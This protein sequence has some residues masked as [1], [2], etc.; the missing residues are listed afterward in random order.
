MELDLE[1]LG[2]EGIHAI[3]YHQH[4]TID[5]IEHRQVEN[6]SQKIRML[7]K[8]SGPDLE[9]LGPLSLV[10]FEIVGAL[11]KELKLVIGVVRE[12]ENTCQV[13]VKLVKVPKVRIIVSVDLLGDIIHD[14]KWV[15]TKQIFNLHKVDKVQQKGIFKGQLCLFQNVIL[16]KGKEFAKHLWYKVLQK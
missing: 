9:L 8:F 5:G 10:L 12:P 2:D 15:A 1:I 3:V 4:R 16:I 13:H 14:P 7:A 6:R 11:K